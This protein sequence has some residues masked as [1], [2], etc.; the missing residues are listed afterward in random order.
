MGVG[1]GVQGG[2]FAPPYASA[3]NNILLISQEMDHGCGFCH[4]YWHPPAFFRDLCSFCVS[5]QWCTPIETQS[6]ND[7]PPYKSTSN[8]I[9]RYQTKYISPKAK[10]NQDGKSNHSGVI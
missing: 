7:A 2:A 6:P 10:E 9:H 4:R 3:F 8:I 5:V 1:R